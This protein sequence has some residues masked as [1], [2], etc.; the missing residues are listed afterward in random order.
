MHKVEI[1]VLRD[2]ADF[3]AMTPQYDSWNTIKT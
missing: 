2:S 3:C 1:K